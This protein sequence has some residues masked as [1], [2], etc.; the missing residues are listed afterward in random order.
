MRLAGWSTPNVAYRYM[1]IN[2]STARRAAEATDR[3]NEQ[4]REAGE[5]VN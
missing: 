1:N 3:L 5:F 2:E 4:A